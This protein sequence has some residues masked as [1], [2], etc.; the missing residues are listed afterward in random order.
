MNA[1]PNSL[2]SAA[3]AAALT[4]DRARPVAAEDRMRRYAVMT[5][6]VGL[7]MGVGAGRQWF[8][9]RA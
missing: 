9:R 1:Q 3:S 8:R 5:A 7:W 2:F 6:V 4:A